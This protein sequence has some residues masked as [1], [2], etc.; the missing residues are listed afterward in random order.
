[1]I[2]ERDFKKK[3]N[4][5]YYF[6]ICIFLFFSPLSFGDN[7]E[8]ATLM[9]TYH[10]NKTMKERRCGESSRCQNRECMRTIT[11]Q[12]CLSACGGEDDSSCQERCT[13]TTLQNPC[14]P[15]VALK[16]SCDNAKVDLE[17]SRK[18]INDFR[19]NQQ[20]LVST[21]NDDL[22]ACQRTGRECT[23][24][25]AA[26][27]EAQ[28][29][30]NKL[31]SDMNDFKALDE[32]NRSDKESA[33]TEVQK[34]RRRQRL[35]A[36]VAAAGTV[37]LTY[38]ATQECG[39]S[40]GMSPTCYI[41]I[42]LATMAGMQT[43]KMW[44]KERELGDTEKGL[45]DFNPSNSACNGY[46]DPKNNPDNNPG[47]NPKNPTPPPPG[48]KQNPRLYTRLTPPLNNS[49]NTFCTPGEI[50][51]SNIAYPWPPSDDK[52]RE[53]IEGETGVPDPDGKKGDG[54]S[55]ETL[56]P[57]EK[58]DVD[59]FLKK[60]NDEGMNYLQEQGIDVDEIDESKKN[61]L[62]GSAPSTSGSFSGGGSKGRSLASSPLP[63]VRKKKKLALSD[64]M[65]GMLKKFQNSLAGG[66]AN[67]DFSK[68][69]VQVGSDVVGVREDNIFMMVHRRHRALDGSG[70][71]IKDAF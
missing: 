17:N 40:G 11:N 36:T 19:T 1:M 65:S 20:N 28:E 35:Y 67:N 32:L 55:Y 60:M 13:E 64:E 6:L 39:G 5:K 16:T 23:E 66:G 61:T 38:K 18:A 31:D 68:K 22:Q 12:S 30:L 62:L 10:A 63:V 4:I 53:M 37:A 71:F 2:K 46:G 51:C 49:Q 70:R 56:N 59:S 54:F 52:I 8:R 57:K 45:C 14:G 41:Y 24:E 58:A 21:T 9:S 47:N 33:L 26:Y 15:C 43:V 7:A 50:G 27:D 42:G 29:N 34:E 69:S 25:Q 48:A 3:N 44:N